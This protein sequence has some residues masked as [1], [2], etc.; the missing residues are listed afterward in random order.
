MLNILGTTMDVDSE[1]PDLRLAY[2]TNYPIRL[3]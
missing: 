1:H 2:D 3:K